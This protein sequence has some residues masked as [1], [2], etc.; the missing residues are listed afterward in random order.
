MGRL[1]NGAAR[2]A[3]IAARV[4]EAPWA[5]ASVAGQPN[6]AV[7]HGVAATPRLRLRLRTLLIVVSLSILVVPL[8]GLYALR[9]HEN[10]LLR[11]TQAELALV[12]TFV[13]TAYRTAFHNAAL[14]DDGAA[15]EPRH[16]APANPLSQLPELDFGAVPVLPA[17]PAAR[18]TAP[19]TDAASRLGAEVAPLL[20]DARTIMYAS[21]RVVDADGVVV[22]TTEDDLG[23]SLTHAQE[24]RRALG[25]APVGTL[26]GKINPGPVA[27][28]A[29]IVRGAALEVFLAL[30][31]RSGQRI[32]GAALVSRA[33]GNILDTL[34]N[35]RALLLQV[36]AVF[37]V[38]AMGIALV[39]ARTL[40]LPIKRL[41]KGAGRVSR[42]ETD[43]FERGR[44]YRVHELADLADSIETMV[45]SLQRR[46]GYVR[47][48]AHHVSH[49]FKTPIAAARGAVELLRDDL[50]DMTPAEAAKFVNNIAADVERLDRLTSRLV[51]LAQADMTPSGNET[52]D[53][54]AV[55]QALALPIVHVA[56]VPPAAAR[57]ARAS[58]LAVL[59]NLV[60]NAARHGAT[61]VD[62][63]A[64]RRGD[65]VELT[66]ADDGPG[67]S[68]ANRGRVF[69]PFFT[70]RQEDGGTG[71]GLAICRS[72]VQGAGGR[73]D[74]V[75]AEQGAAFKVTL[76]ASGT[77]R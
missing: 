37:L 54:V 64:R 7:R 12:A 2:H 70:T 35:Q 28:V 75:P 29:P 4:A 30:P 77:G 52:T 10:T 53:V 26:R 11:Q 9:L 13:A 73:I 32:I 25:G 18:P 71:L 58:L 41:V 74:L 56:P 42:G 24:V 59:E 5:E 65:T 76:I 68:P 15:G 69:D 8:V 33:A 60:D 20:R 46:A 22:A 50:P 63:D 72:L 51:D 1:P 21:V 36:G 34:R 44:H 57:I 6:I 49:E 38:V 45:A 23:L 3:R 14:R 66:V 48:F 31:I 40:M 62:V 39:T 27:E 67:I 17:F 43:Q 61:R 19:A 16:A 55:A 47:D